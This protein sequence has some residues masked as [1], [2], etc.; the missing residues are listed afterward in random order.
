MANNIGRGR[1]MLTTNKMLMILSE[2]FIL[3]FLE[4]ANL[5]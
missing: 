5:V 2:N 1:K 3:K 4:Y